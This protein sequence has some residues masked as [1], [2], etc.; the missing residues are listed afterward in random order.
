M[1]ERLDRITR[2]DPRRLALLAVELQSRVDELERAGRAPLAVIG[3]GC[4]FPGG[5]DDPASFWRLLADGV[6]AIT[7]V[8]PERW[9]VDAWY[10]PD[11]EKPGTMAT[12]YGGFVRDVDRF[13]AQ[14]FGIAPREAASMDPQ[15]RLLLEVAWEAL[16]HAGLSA[17][18]LAGSRTGVF[19]GICNSDYYQM[20]LEADP[21]AQD[22]YVATGGAHSVAAGRLAYVLGLQGPNLAV[23]TACSSSLVAVHLACRSLR[24][25]ECRVALAAGVNLILAPHVTVLLSRGRMMAPDGRCKAF[26]A[27]AD[28]FVRAEGCG[29]VVLKRLADAL[30]DGDPVLAVIRGTALNQDG[31]SNGLTAP[32]GPSQEAVLREALADAG[33]AAADVGYVEAHGTGT[34]L[35]DPIELQALGAALGA[36]RPADRPLLVGS[37]K[38]NLGHL[39]AAAGVAGLIK[40]VLALQHGEIPASLH[41]ERPN[42]HVAWERLPVTVAARRQPWPAGPRIAGVSSFGFSGTNAHVIVEAAAPAPPAPPAS[43]SR[44]IALSARTE[45]ALRRLAGRWAE[46]LATEGAPLVDAAFTSVAGRAAHEHRLAVLAGSCAEASAA[47]AAVARGEAPAIGGRAGRRAPGVAVLFTGQGAQWPG[48]GR[49]LYEQEPAFR[50]ALDRCAAA[51]RDELKEPLLDVLWGPASDRLDDTR[52][53][54]PALFAVEWALAEL[55]RAWGVEPAAVLGH[56]AGEYA[57]ACVAGV[58][59]VEDA[60]RLVAARGRVLGALP[61]GGGM[62][63]AWESE[64]R[65]REVVAPWPAVEF[66]AVNGPAAVV[67]SG[68]L[69]DLEAACRALESLGVKTERLRVSYAAHSSMLDPMLDEFAAVAAAVRYRPAVVPFVSTLT[70]RLAAPDEIARADYWV[71]QTREPVR[72]GDAV[73][74]ARAAGGELFVEAG[75]HPVLANLGQQSVTDATWVGTLRRGRADREQALEAAATL[76]TRGVAVDLARAQPGRRV[77]GLPT[78]PFERDRHWVQPARGRRRAGS[79]AS[80][81]PLLGARVRSAVPVPHFEAVLDAREPAFLAD[82][83]VHDAVIAPAALYVEMALAAGART[84]GGALELHDLSIER[85]LLL[86]AEGE[87]VVQTVVREEAGATRVEIA[88]LDGEGDAA[89]WLRHAAASLRPAPAPPGRIDL[90]AIR[91]RCA[92]ARLPDAHYARLRE[93]GVEFGPAFQGIARLARGAGE[94]LAEVRTPPVVA[95]EAGRYV[96]HPAVLDAC[97]QALAA[98]GPDDDEPTALVVGAD[99]VWLS[100]CPERVWSHAVVSGSE[101]AGGMRSAD[102]RLADADGRLVGELLGVRLRR[103]RREA[104]AGRGV[105]ADWLYEVTW[106]ASPVPAAGASTTVALPAPATLAAQAEA[107]FRAGAAAPAVV[108]HDALVPALESLATAH[109]VAALRDLGWTPRVGEAVDLDGLADRL[110][111]VARHRRLLGRL[112]DVLVEDGILRRAAGG[113]EALAALPAADPDARHA[114]L[115]RRDG[116]DGPELGLTHDCGRALAD[117]LRG[118]RD[119]LPLLFSDETLARTE[120]IY[121]A[122]PVARVYNQLVADVVARAVAA[123]PAGRARVLEVGAGT[124]GTTAAVLPALGGGCAEYAVTDVSPRFTARAAETF[125]AFGFVRCQPLDVERDPAAQGFE[126]E[127]YDVVVAANVLHATRDLAATLDHVRRLLAPGGLLVLLEGTRPHRWVDVTFGLTEG[128][129]R[130][131]DAAVRP[132]HPLLAPARW[133]DVLGAAGFE[134][135]AVLTD[136]GGRA[137]LGSQAVLL[138]RRGGTAR[139]VRPWLLRADDG[140]V[141]AA[142]AE[143]LRARGERCEVV[144]ADDVGPALARLAAADGCR[145]VV[146]LSSLDAPA[147]DALSPAQARREL[148]DRTAGLVSV[149]RAAVSAGGEEP[150]RLWLVTRGAQAVA[151]D[152]GAVAVGQAAAW[153]LGRVVALEHPARW[154]GL[155]DLDPAASVETCAEQLAR[156]LALGGDEDQVAFRRGDR[157]VPRLTRRAPPAGAAFAPAADGSYLVTGGLG[158]LGL[159]VARWLAERGARHLVLV[160]RRGA[161]PRETWATLPPDGDAGRQATALATIEAAGA[162]VDVVAADV[163]DVAAMRRLLD[164]LAAEGRSLR[165]VVHTAAG[166]RTDTLADTTA[167]ALDV[168]LGAKAAGAL[169]LHALTRDLP[170]DCFVLFSSTTALV[171]S[172]GLGHYAAANTVLDALAHHRRRR[173]AAALAVNW[174][175]WEEMRAASAEDRRRYAQGGLRPMPVASALDALGGLLGEGTPQATVASIDWTVLRP[176]YEAR[177]RRPLLAHLGVAPAAAALPSA[178]PAGLRARLAAAAPEQR[179]DLVVDQV[180]SDVGRIL[181]LAPTD[182]DVE[183]GLFDMGMDSLMALD[184]KT[185]LEAA[186]G[187]RLPSTLTFNYPT[188]AALAGYLLEHVLEPAPPAPA[189][190]SPAPAAPGG[191]RDDMSEDELA[192]LLAARLGG[193]R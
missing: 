48:M 137:A 30:A 191:A 187:A 7:E 103:V 75:P 168:A 186:V 9:D 36:G 97:L 190:A 91:A 55:W 69:A 94:A 111:V 96:V 61:P 5:A 83:R 104:L 62:A 159:N 3:L 76:W 43:G 108:A 169:V 102:V 149:A 29:V 172:A 132:A 127:R 49:E 19:V 22:A 113:W 1:T 8:P 173:G 136:T 12:R 120:S 93:R 25:G 28:G 116:L 24:A 134:A 144:G 131:A 124:G 64:A 165:G 71:R 140:G 181:G 2:L 44:V 177:R 53:T 42:P 67:L 90:E 167:D 50:A 82:H 37:V 73:R 85:P 192:A 13:D 46:A 16:E 138:A 65:V 89:T 148:V 114:E 57:A 157:L 95:A 164:G 80:G 56:S 106:E 6:D 72:F 68:P 17:D 98:A 189:P 139:T 166:L 47:L 4:R 188:V 151:G 34:S 176:L 21:A 41:F 182:I 129:W 39:E 26:D 161:P 78:Y 141:A 155:V 99:R 109:V 115:R 63:A 38:T 58:L 77:S 100:P 18:R 15:Q 121:A 156:Q 150:G 40:T 184:V 117:V 14:F 193:A 185:R 70:G 153:G 146:D 133:T 110:A 23:D 11:P 74:A 152:D 51:L 118:T 128:W 31:R 174:G 79:P 126:G 101:T 130:F 81:H 143:R 112:L 145:G 35:G 170:L 33:L 60:V 158:G 88:A 163:T 54:Q 52:W 123:L 147:V 180:R 27:R 178:P 20:L 10:D 87:R 92:E 135:C 142:V 125:R 179:G 32:N 107:A 105:P 59:Q 45:P 175:T 122:S 84:L 160:G 86:P 119:P 171:G 66:A 183:R 154:G 162:R